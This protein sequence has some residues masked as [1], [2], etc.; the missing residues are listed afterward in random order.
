MDSIETNTFEDGADD[1]RTVTIN[2]E[3]RGS[4]LNYAMSV[5]V[6]RALPDAR[7]GLKPVHRRILFAMHDMGLRPGAAYKKSARLVGEVLGKYHPHGDQAIYDAMA[8][9]AQDFSLRYPLVDGQGNFGSQDGDK[10]AAMRYTEARM[11]NIASELMTDINMDTVDF[12]D[13]YDQTQEEPTVLPARLPNLLLNGASG[14]AVGMATSIPPHNLRELAAAITYLIDNYSRSESVTVD[15]LMQFIKGP[16]FPT[17]AEIVVGDELKE[18]YATG[19]GRV[20][21][22]SGADFEERGDGISIVIRSIPYQVSKSA[23][24]ERIVSLVRDGRIE[25]I[26]D[27][28]DESDRQGLRLVVELKRHAQPQ[29]V[30]NQLYKYTQLQSVYSIQ[31]LALVNGEPRTLSLKRSLQIYIEHRYDVIVRRSE[32]DLKRQRARAHVL[33]G[34]LKAV[35]N[36][37]E[38]IRT[39]R[40]SE[41]VESART[42]LMANLELDEIQANAILDMQ[43]RRLSALERQ[44]L[45]EEF[46]AVQARISYLE[47]LL[48]SP[49][50]ILDLIR[51]DVQEI[52]EK[53][54]DDR[55]TTVSYGNVDLDEGDLYRREN[56]VISLTENGYIKRVAARHYRAQRRGGKGM[57]GF[58][59]HEGEALMDVFFAYSHDTILFFSNLGK[60]Y[61]CVAYEIAETQRERRGSPIQLLLPLE[62]DEEVSAILALPEDRIEEEVGYFILATSNG[63]V[64]RVEQSAFSN[65]RYSG[66]IAMNIPPGDALRWVKWTAGDQDIVM[67]SLNGQ[68]IRFR[69]DD[70]RAMGRPAAGV[71]GMAL[72]EDDEIAGMDAVCADHSHVLVVTRNGYGKCT[73]LDEY[74]SQRR[75]GIGV[76]T[77]RRNQKTGPV[78]AVRCIR[79][80]DGIVLVSKRGIVLRTQL[81]EIRETGRNTQGVKL[82]NLDEGD[83]VAGIAIMNGADDDK[84]S[85][86][87]DEFDR[88]SEHNGN[89]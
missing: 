18:A 20:A 27:L 36:I 46:D 50:K 81:S 84:P 14:I 24:I 61:S 58:R 47:D 4:Y 72:R 51:E 9:M 39:I 67:A 74:D 75:Y 35:A 80:K 65:I 62:S 59:L 31:M 11:A 79:P 86:S 7:D 3:M 55:N 42:R 89:K 69:E 60:V 76:R 8:R 82:M 30:L 25:A 29:R 5:I 33:S 77:L 44:K 21:V 22:R 43:L 12:T 13:N 54:G 16:D 49:R 57:K 64:K 17:G 1:V 78:I 26:R 41:N 34:L 6:A 23:I 52:A 87:S 53:Y 68:S 71:M 10:P 45:Q 66:L 28:R 19:K 63:K 56:V 40:N 15:D 70:V 38:V 88:A 37:D 48:A 2:E 85:I 83:H 32:H 73:K